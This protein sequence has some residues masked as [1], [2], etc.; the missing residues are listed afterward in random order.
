MRPL[1][2]SAAVILS[3]V[4]CRA[5]VLFLN[6]GE[7]I[8]GTVRALDAEKL[9]FESAGK[10]KDHLRKDV[11]RVKFVREW[12]IPGEDDPSKISDVPLRDFLKSPPSPEE[13]PEDGYLTYLDETSC[14]FGRDRKARCSYRTIR[15]V[16]RER[17]RDR[18][19][20]ARLYCLEGVET[21][22]IGHA[23]SISAGKISYLDDTSVQEGSE[24][25]EY[26]AYNRLKSL[27]FSIPDVS[28][29]S[30]ADYRFEDEMSVD[31]STY[32]F[33]RRKY[34]RFSEP[35]RVSRLVVSV[36]KD[37]RLEHRERLMPKD[38]IFKR[39]ES[40]GEVRYLWEVR[41]SPSFKNEDMTPPYGRMAP[42][43][44]I[45]L[46]DTWEN[47]SASISRRI[48]ERLAVG[49]DLAAKTKEL[50]AGKTAPLDKVEALYNWVAKEIKLQNVSMGEYGFVPKTPTEI[51]L[52]KAG[53]KLDKPFLLY[54]M[55]RQ[56]GF[57]P[58]L[59]YMEN[60]SDPPFD[61]SLPSLQQ[62][63]AAASVLTVGG[64]TL[65]LAPL[66][67]SL[68]YNETPGWLQDVN[69]LIVRGRL[70]GGP[71]FF[72]PILE[73]SRESESQTGRV[74][75]RADGS[76]VGGETFLPVGESHSGWRGLKRLNKEELDKR[77]ERLVH[78]IHPNA[79]LIS[80]SIKNLDDLS[81]DVTVRFDYSIQDYAI[82]ASGG[83]LAFRVPWLDHSASDV[84]EPQ[85]ESPMFWYQRER[86]TRE[87]SIALPAGYELYHAPGAVSLD[88]PG[89]SYRA[90]YKAAGGVLVF[91][92][93]STRDVT[94][95]PVADY[96]RYKSYREQIA[97]FTEQWI[98]LKKK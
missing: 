94:E 28:T 50:V 87:V 26:P 71:L 24:Y 36:P 64:K 49:P 73:G 96:A 92:E 34:F 75:L 78:G 32:S 25:P 8:S 23:R 39:E 22:G 59:V 13:Y 37:M 62:F 80:Y 44:V 17:G 85:R 60:K 21:C 16:L 97:R 70:P 14:R 1:I 33:L 82:T 7:E 69:G 3:T 6:G 61:A 81:R 65:F 55:L 79:R 58:A 67:D 46:A 30:V 19:A 11:L 56:A 41:R 77:M 57:D 51:F 63:D 68:R 38:A 54:I 74:E 83:Y 93:T 95:L 42:F 2:L 9:S 76:L 90:T 98:V 89:G 20:N 45:A 43:V 18:S 4:D 52:A 88:G 86:E 48:Q 66:S 27:K 12:R 91:S 84:G 47:V 72:N 15:L 5:D 35:S 10:V 53:N 31:I 40:G 29:G